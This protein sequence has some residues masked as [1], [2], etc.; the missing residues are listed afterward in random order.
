MK[1]YFGDALDEMIRELHGQ[2]APM[3]RVHVLAKLQGQSL[4]LSTYVTTFCN[5]QVYEA[6]VET[7]VDLKGVDPGQVPDFVQH[8][9]EQT[10]AAVLKKLEGFEIRRGILQE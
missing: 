5:Q 10:R 8:Q 7:P 3:V 6:V 9:R 2:G 4:V 1:L